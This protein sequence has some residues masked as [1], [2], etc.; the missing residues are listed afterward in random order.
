MHTHKSVMNAA[1]IIGGEKCFF[2][3]GMTVKEYS[4]YGHQSRTSKTKQNL[5]AK[6]MVTIYPATLFPS[7]YP[8]NF[9]SYH[10]GTCL[11]VLLVM[12]CSQYLGNEISLDVHQPMNG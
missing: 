5:K 7:K 1:G 3:V 8:K 9:T 6:D 4:P 2:D 11:C 10:R 12:F